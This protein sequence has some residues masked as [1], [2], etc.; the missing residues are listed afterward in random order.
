MKG[1]ALPKSQGNSSFYTSSSQSNDTLSDNTLSNET[2][3]SLSH[4]FGENQSEEQPTP[5]DNEGDQEAD[6]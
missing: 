2:F 6:E 5:S 1:Q 3:T 4:S